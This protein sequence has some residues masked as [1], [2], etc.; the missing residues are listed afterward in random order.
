[1]TNLGRYLAHISSISEIPEI[2]L[3]TSIFCLHG[4]NNL[5]V[6]LQNLAIHFQTLKNYILKFFKNKKGSQIR[7]FSVNNF[8]FY[9]IQK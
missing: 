5:D 8:I 6:K 2:P 7:I 9:A 1:L 3:P 4:K